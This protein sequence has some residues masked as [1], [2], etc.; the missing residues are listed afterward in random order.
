MEIGPVDQA[1]FNAALSLGTIWPRRGPSMPPMHAFRL[2][3]GW[4]ASPLPAC[5]LEGTYYALR[6]APSAREPPR[7]VSGSHHAIW[8]C[9]HHGFAIAGL[10]PR[11]FESCSSPVGGPAP[12]ETNSSIHRES[13]SCKRATPDSRSNAGVARRGMDQRGQRND[14]RGAMDATSRRY[15]AGAQPHHTEARQGRF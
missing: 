8:V 11:T 12:I 15:D 14:R 6:R 3:Y 5:Y 7:F 9:H 2:R 10:V 1:F 13:S 4:F